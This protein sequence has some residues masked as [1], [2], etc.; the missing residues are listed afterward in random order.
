[1]AS[2][3]DKFISH[4]DALRT[5]LFDPTQAF[6][7]ETL[8]AGLVDHWEQIR[9]YGGLKATITTEP[10]PLGVHRNHYWTGH[11][12]PT[13]HSFRDMIGEP[14]VLIGYGYWLQGDGQVAP[15]K[16]PERVAITPIDPNKTT[17]DSAPVIVLRYFDSILESIRSINPD[18]VQG[19]QEAD[20]HLASLQIYTTSL[21]HRGQLRRSHETAIR[22]Y[23]NGENPVQ[24]SEEIKLAKVEGD[25]AEQLELRIQYDAPSNTTQQPVTWF[26]NCEYRRE[27]LGGDYLRLDAYPQFTILR[28]SS[29]I[30][31]GIEFTHFAHPMEDLKKFGIEDDTTVDALGKLC[32]QTFPFNMNLVVLA[33]S[34]AEA[35]RHA[36]SQY[37]ATSVPTD[38]F[39]PRDYQEQLT[40]FRIDNFSFIGPPALHR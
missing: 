12:V 5:R 2:E 28:N 30:P 4:V 7:H 33:D 34:L 11:N 38:E 15:H 31:I 1:M 9:T 29:G 22:I 16:L 14:K 24:V 8:V 17:D 27:T 18:R 6:Q 13:P 26:G 3:T 39:N 36:S 32:F 10:L 25:Q 40:R 23:I 19:M 37:P 35:R 21:Q 20:G